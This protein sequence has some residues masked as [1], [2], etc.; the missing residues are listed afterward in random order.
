MNIKNICIYLIF[1]KL[2]NESYFILIEQNTT[3]FL[4]E[5]LNSLTKFKNI[6]LV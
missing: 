2:K 1:Y 4:S 3:I 5:K 6:K